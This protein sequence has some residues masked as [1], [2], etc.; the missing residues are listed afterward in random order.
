MISLSPV[1][2][3]YLVYDLISCLFPSNLAWT[4]SPSSTAMR[5][6]FLIGL[7]CSVVTYVAY[8]AAIVS[9]LSVSLVPVERF[10]DL[11]V[12]NFVFTVHKSSDPFQIFLKVRNL[13]H[14]RRY[15]KRLEFKVFLCI[16]FQVLNS[17]LLEYY[18]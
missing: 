15:F 17:K 8:S 7:F 18:P 12:F 14:S 4:T 3:G 9:T 16:H 2:N 1:S 5:M 11:L 13:S 6:A 10:L